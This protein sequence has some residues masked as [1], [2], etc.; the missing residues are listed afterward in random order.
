MATAE[1]QAYFKG[2]GKRLSKSSNKGFHFGQSRTTPKGPDGE[3]MK[4]TICDSEFHF[5]AKCPRRIQQQSGSSSSTRVSLAQ[6]VTSFFIRGPHRWPR[7]GGQRWTSFLHGWQRSTTPTTHAPDSHPATDAWAAG[8]DPWVNA[9][10]PPDPQ[11]QASDG[12]EWNNYRNPNRSTSRQGRQA[13]TDVSS[14]QSWVMSTSLSES[15]TEGHSEPGPADGTVNPF[16]ERFQ[17]QFRRS[18][19]A[20]GLP[21]TPAPPVE[22]GPPGIQGM[23]P[24][25]QGAWSSANVAQCRSLFSKQQQTSRSNRVYAE[26]PEQVTARTQA[27]INLGNLVWNALNTGPSDPIFGLNDAT[28]RT[29]NRGATHGRG[30]SYAATTCGAKKAQA[31]RNSESAIAATACITTT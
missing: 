21:I 17:T 4:C 9:T 29:A 8:A 28:D 12:T 7:F 5:L 23:G 22:V 14:E 18:V 27:R 1:G 26:T 19:P 15:Q 10:L 31:A 20:I 16:V 13:A 3:V 24:G 11:Q 25:I 6:N 30:A 2:E